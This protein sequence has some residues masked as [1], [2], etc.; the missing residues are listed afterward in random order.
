MFAIV[1]FAGIG[2]WLFLQG[3]ARYCELRT[4][5]IERRNRAKARQDREAFDERMYLEEVHKT[6]RE[7]RQARAKAPSAAALAPAA[8]IPT[9]FS[10]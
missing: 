6:A 5:A 9:T 2:I 7:Q 4:L 3:L 1:F 8:A 10:Y